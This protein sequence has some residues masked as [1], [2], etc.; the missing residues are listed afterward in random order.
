[1]GQSFSAVEA[2][3]LTSVP[4]MFLVRFKGAS[5]EKF[6]TFYYTGPQNPSKEMFALS[7]SILTPF[8]DQIS[9]LLKVSDPLSVASILEWIRNYAPYSMTE[10]SMCVRQYAI[11]GSYSHMNPFV[12]VISEGPPS[13]A[14]PFTRFLQQ[15]GMVMYLGQIVFQALFLILLMAQRGI[16][17]NAMVVKQMYI[18]PLDAPTHTVFQLKTS[19]G[20]DAL[21]RPIALTIRYKLFVSGLQNLASFQFKNNF[22]TTENCGL[23]Q[24]RNLPGPFFRECNAMQPRREAI[25]FLCNLLQQVS[26][27]SIRRA[28]LTVM[29][30]PHVQRHWD[31][32]FRKGCIL[33]DVGWMDRYSNFP[34]TW[35]LLARAEKWCRLSNI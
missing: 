22:A 21:P 14:I 15:P 25:V 30:S 19:S 24:F 28:L 34:S 5:R 20:Q 33:A 18:V 27:P 23:V 3:H 29:E 10:F 13:N 9:I 35:T 26:H 7:K 16:V 4:N 12:Y 32:L 1:M 17:L 6:L 31:R 8:Q 2:L 11:E